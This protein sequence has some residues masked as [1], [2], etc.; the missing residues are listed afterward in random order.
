[1][2]H[3]ELDGCTSDGELGTVRADSVLTTAGELAQ[4]VLIEATSSR[5]DELEVGRDKRQQGAEEQL[6]LHLDRWV[7]RV[8][9][10]VIR[11]L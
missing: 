8:K 4:V 7:V 5:V 1:V 10:M 3:E 2:A 6:D 9:C 11:S